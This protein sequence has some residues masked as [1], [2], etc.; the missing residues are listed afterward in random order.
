MKRR[1]GGMVKAALGISWEG[2]NW[3]VLSCVCMCAGGVKEE[4]EM[5]IC[6]IRVWGLGEERWLLGG[7][8]EGGRY[9]IS[10]FFGAWDCESPCIFIPWL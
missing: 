2:L 6:G 10:I 1:L 5:E 9:G 7:D 3:E 8:G 4:E